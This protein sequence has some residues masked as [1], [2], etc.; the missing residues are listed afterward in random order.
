MPILKYI[1]NIDAEDLLPYKGLTLK[2][3]KIDSVSTIIVET[4][5]VIHNAIKSGYVPQSF[6]VKEK[7]VNGK[8]K[9]LLDQFPDAIVYTAPDELLHKL[10]GFPLTRGI[11]SAMACPERI[12]E[13]DLIRRSSRLLILENIQDASNI[14][15]IMR[16]ACSLGIGG[17]LLDSSCCN[18][19]HRKSIRTSMGAVFQI[20]WAVSKRVGY[21]LASFLN[22]AGFR[23]MAFAIS[24]QA[25]PLQKAIKN[26]HGALA[27]FFGSEGNGLDQRTIQSCRD[28]VMIPMQN[29]FD[30][31]NVSVAVSIA[32]WE[33]SKLDS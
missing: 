12:S 15:S 17:V 20:P 14:G 19:F 16:S 8:Y 21:E 13:D 31:L 30:S 10:T 28:I 27:L 26:A 6:L 3:S 2:E 32:L 5:T 11:L 25:I 33:C 22:E 4:G 24:P 1:S 9:A 7:Y 23:T 18:P 29:D